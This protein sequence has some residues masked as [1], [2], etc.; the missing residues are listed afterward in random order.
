MRTCSIDGC[1]RKH[2]GRGYCRIHF[3][4]WKR[5]GDPLYSQIA[6][7][8]DPLKFI[9]ESVARAKSGCT[10]CILWP[11]GKGA[12]GYGNLAHKSTKQA[13]RLAL[14]LFTGENPKYLGALHGPCNNKL[15]V[16][17]S[18]L[19]WGDQAKNVGQDR[20]RDGTVVTNLTES[21]VLSIYKDT[22]LDSVIAKE[23]SVSRSA[24][25]KIKTG[26]NWGWLTGH[27]EE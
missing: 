27:N 18:H 25:G 10:Q 5:Y 16:N 22:R 2:H 12:H 6:S 3:R 21:Q 13:H 1:K 19:S 20:K 4:K 8:G 26:K 17:P 15:C 9:E 7:Q 14:I 23:Y 24:I 11:Y